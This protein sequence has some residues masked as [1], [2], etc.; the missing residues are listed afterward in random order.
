MATPP[1][2]EY[3]LQLTEEERNELLFLVD[4]ALR[5][6]HAERRR[7]EAPAYQERVRREESVIR[8]LAE[9]VHRLGR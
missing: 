4:Q 9:K 7:T 1:T 6:V 3:T 8:S 2:T 5:D